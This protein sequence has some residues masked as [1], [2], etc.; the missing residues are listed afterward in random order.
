MT[1]ILTTTL[2]SSTTQPNKNPEKL[3]HRLKKIMCHPQN[4]ENQKPK[5]KLALTTLAPSSTTQPNK[6]S[7]KLI[8]RLKKIK[9]KSQNH[10]ITKSQNHKI[11]KSQMTL[12]LTT[13]APS[14]TT[15]HKNIKQHSI[16][17]HLI[18]QNFKSKPIN[19]QKT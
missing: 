1:L 7:E 16:K 2:P 12:I 11:T 19:N 10:K 6:N 18:K 15:Q 5:M 9:R 3:I 17:S 4:N 13:I 14:S 8:H